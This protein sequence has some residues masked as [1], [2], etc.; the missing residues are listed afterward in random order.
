MPGELAHAP[1]PETGDHRA[2]RLGGQGLGGMEPPAQGLLGAVRMDPQ[3]HLLHRVLIDAEAALHEGA[4][5]EV[6][7]PRARCRRHLDLPH[8]VQAPGARLGGT[9]LRPHQV[10]GALEDQAEGG[11]LPLPPGRRAALVLELQPAQGLDRLPHHIQ[12]RLVLEWPGTRMEGD[13]L[14]LQQGLQVWRQPAPRAGPHGRKHL[15][16]DTGQ[17]VGPGAGPQLAEIVRR[18][19][20]G[21]EFVGGGRLEDA[22]QAGGN[23]EPQGGRILHLLHLREGLAHGVPHPL[24]G[25]T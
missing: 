6:R 4:Q 19:V 21:G 7:R 16:L 22:V 18:G 15:L 1:R 2:V 3:H 17:G 12:H 9:S 8:P 25:A 20:Q 10:V 11:H 23:P 24:G 13:G 14:G 5:V